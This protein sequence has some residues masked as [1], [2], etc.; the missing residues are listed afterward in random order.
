M[1]GTSSSYP[2]HDTSMDGR[3]HLTNRVRCVP[4]QILKADTVKHVQCVYSFSSITP[5]FSSATPSQLPLL[6]WPGVERGRSRERR[7]WKHLPGE[8]IFYWDV[9]ARPRDSRRHGRGKQMR[10]GTAPTRKGTAAGLLWLLNRAGA[11]AQGFEDAAGAPLP[12]PWLLLPLPLF[13]L[14]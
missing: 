13:L 8:E 5:N 10:G 1:L 3:M 6:T 9:P 2:A 4:G 7:D 14:P 11:K 12:P